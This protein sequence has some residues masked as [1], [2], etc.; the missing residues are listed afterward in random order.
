MS[1]NDTSAKMAKNN[2]VTVIWGK[3]IVAFLKLA[4][5]AAAFIRVA[6]K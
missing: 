5:Q 3:N 6:N 4:S 2:V 1:W